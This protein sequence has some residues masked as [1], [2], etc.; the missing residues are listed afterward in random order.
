MKVKQLTI[1][2]IRKIKSCVLLVNPEVRKGIEEI[3]TKTEQAH[4]AVAESDPMELNCL[5]T[6]KLMFIP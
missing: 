6:P 2:Y 1:N 5:L 4:G 3:W